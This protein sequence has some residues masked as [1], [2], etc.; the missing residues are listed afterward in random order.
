MHMVKLLQKFVKK[1]QQKNEIR[2]MKN[3]NIWIEKL[4][5]EHKQF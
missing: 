5:E 2:K 4:R 3:E 1:K